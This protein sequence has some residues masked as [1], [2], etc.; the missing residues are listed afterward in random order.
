MQIP[1]RTFL[2]IPVEGMRIWRWRKFW[3]FNFKARSI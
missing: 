2:L 1:A 3:F